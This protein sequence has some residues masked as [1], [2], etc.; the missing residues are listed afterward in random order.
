MLVALPTHISVISP[1]TIWILVWPVICIL[2][3]LTVNLAGVG[4]AG[5]RLTK[6]GNKEIGLYITVC[7]HKLLP[8]HH[9]PDSNNC[10]TYFLTL[11]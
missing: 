5:V 4:G 6:S 3:S 11:M 7:L 2:W 1:E 9:V 8:R 10:A